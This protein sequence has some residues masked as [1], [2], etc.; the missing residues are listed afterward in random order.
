MNN[1]KSLRKSKRMTQQQLADTLGIARTT[2]SHFENGSREMNYDLLIRTADFFDVS[3]DYILGRESELALFDD[4]RVQTPQ[5][6]DI[7]KRLPKE[8]QNKLLAFAKIMLEESNKR[9]FT[10]Q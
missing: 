6:F 1:L 8:E 2:L 3:I 9:P 10:A 7:Y 5:I 4:A